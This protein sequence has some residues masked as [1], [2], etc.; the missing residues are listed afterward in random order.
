M[1]SK[2]KQGDSKYFTTTKKGEIHEL[3][4]ELGS[5]K[6]DRQK[7]ALKKVI[8]AMTV[9]KDVSM[10]FADVVKCV[11]TSDLELKKLIYL[12]IMNYAKSE[13]D[14]VILAVHAFVQDSSIETQSNPLIRALAIRTMSCIRVTKITEYLTT[15]LRQGLKDSDPY[16][17]KT[18]AIAVAKLYDINPELVIDQGF[19]ESLMAL[20]SDSNP[21]VIANAVAALTEIDENSKNQVFRLNPQTLSKLLVALN[22]CTEWGQVFILNSLATYTPRDSREAE[23]HCER[24]TPRL[25]HANSAV[26]LGAVKVLIKYMDQ[27]KSNEVLRGLCKKMAPPLVT[28]LS[29]EPEVQYVALRNINLIIQKRPTI[30][31]YEMKVFFCKYNDPIYVKMEKLEIMIM[32]ASERNIDQV[33]LEFKEYATEV[34]VEF[35]RKSVRAIGRCAIKLGKAAERC[36]HVLLELIQT[37][38]NYVVQEAIIVIKD[39]FRKYPNQYESII[40][41][42]CENLDTLDEPEAKAS[43]IWIIGEYAE[44]IDNADELLESFL[45][46]FHDENTQVQLQLL[47]SVVKLFLKKPKNTQSLVQLA[48]N[49]ATQESDNPDLRDRGFIYWRLLSTDPEAAKAVVLAEKPLI[50]DTTCN[51]E[52]SLLDNLLSHMATL[53]SVYHKPPETFVSKFRR[54][55]RERNADQRN[56]ED[57]NDGGQ[58]QQDND[59]D[60]QQQQQ[61]QQPQQQQ[62]Q[63]QPVGNLL[64]LGDLGSALPP[65]GSGGGGD[66]L[67]GGGS[68]GGGGG[69]G[70]STNLNLVLPGSKGKGM[71]I[72]AAFARRGDQTF[73]D[74]NIA[75]QTSVPLSGFALQF[76]KNTFSLAPAAP[77]D[78]APVMPG[79]SISHSLPVS[80]TGPMSP[81]PPSGAVQ[82][83]IKNN[84]DVFYFQENFPLHLTYRSDGRAEKPEYIQS[85][86]AISNDNEASIDLQGITVNSVESL[87]ERLESNNIFF[88][89]KRRVQD[90]DVVY[91]SLKL[92][93][94]DGIYVEVT[95]F[96]GGQTCKV[97]CKANA[98][99]YVP[100]FF[101]DVRQIL[102]Q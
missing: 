35:V 11:R 32:L 42:L 51:L 56:N 29:K 69:G 16:V 57:Q 64:D 81:G 43:M 86:K 63:Q 95:L 41:T 10:L 96:P 62:Q 12:Y 39:I 4:E 88:V 82:M 84:I 65:Q 72:R 30:L 98:T 59:R 37:K 22:E 15:P 55:R 58:Y 99:D 101:E 46:G 102:T 9:G 21:M 6:A 31:Q 71:E 94:G 2:E 40:A 49:M 87:Q 34:D 25:Q 44:R 100:L 18:A 78:L 36:I 91:H 45:D 74:L 20:L 73:F 90:R 77:L 3:K 8:A 52:P 80:N 26:V 85:W 66:L 13:P 97:C 23:S 17:R 89:A 27:I 47:T 33:L 38:V 76:N 92:A 48:L 28:L 70:A 79:Q 19:I 67:G 54:L 83:A 61:Q 7:E 75:N 93:S 1:S 50:S 14:L 60:Y 68:G 24:V 53:A 5:P